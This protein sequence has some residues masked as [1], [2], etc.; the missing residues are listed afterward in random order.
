MGESMIVSIDRDN[1]GDFSDL[2]FKL[3]LNY[4]CNKNPDCRVWET[5]KGYHVALVLPRPDPELALFY[6]AYLLD[7]FY[8][9]GYDL[10]RGDSLGPAALSGIIFDV[11]GGA[12]KSRA[13]E[14]R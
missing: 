13:K 12:E 8:R 2:L 6:R 10:A 3:R 7:D 5:K 14:V 11:K 4:L 9:L 1:Q